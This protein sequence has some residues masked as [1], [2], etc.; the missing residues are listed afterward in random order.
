VVTDTDIH[1]TNPVSIPVALS[2]KPGISVSSEMPWSS[3][4]VIRGLTKDQI[5][6]LVD[7]CRVV[8]ATATAAQFG[9]IANGDIERIELLKGPLSV[10]YGSGSTGGIVNVIT[11]RGRFTP[12][13]SF[14]L[15][16]NPTSKAR[17]EVFRSTRGRPGQ[18]TFLSDVFTVEPQVHRLSR[19][20]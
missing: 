7:G 1:E 17:P 2:R 6:L 8:T 9:T 16:V 19:S 5:I 15:S 12:E 18:L 20:R 4:P 3:R 13:P 14:N 11:R 10:L